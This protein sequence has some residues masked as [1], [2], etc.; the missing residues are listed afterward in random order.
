[1]REVV[2]F[3][4][5][6]KWQSRICINILTGAMQKNTEGLTEGFCGVHPHLWGSSHLEWAELS[7]RPYPHRFEAAVITEGGEGGG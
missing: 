3:V 5:I 2:G 7:L 1:V 4:C 6:W